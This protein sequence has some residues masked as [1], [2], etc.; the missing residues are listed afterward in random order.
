[1]QRDVD[2]TVAVVGSGP[3]GAA[4]AAYLAEAGV[5]TLL[6]DHRRFP[7]SKACGEYLN[8]LAVAR[9][10]ELGVAARL[11]SQAAILRGMRLH[12]HHESV[13]FPFERELWSLPRT[14]MDDAIRRRA[15]SAGAQPLTARVL[16]VEDEAQSVVLHLRDE[17]GVKRAVRAAYAVGA[18]GMHSTVARRKIPD[19]AGIRFAVGG[20]YRIGTSLEG[21]VEMFRTPVGYLALNPL[22][23]GNANAMCV[24]R[25]EA[26]H[27]WRHDVEGAIRD[28]S[29]EASNG[30]RTLEPHARDGERVSI[31]PLVPFER[32]AT[33][34]HRVLVGDA[35]AFLDPFTGQGIAF[36]LTGASLASAA[37]VRVLRQ[38]DSQAL[39]EYG[40]SIARFVRE[41]R[42]VAQLIEVVLQQRILA[43]IA[44]HRVRESPSL[45]R[46]LVELV[47]GTSRDES[48]LLALTHLA[49]AAL[50]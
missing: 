43:H 21:W 10:A 44:A 3:A 36:A 12:A 5:D 48:P 15:I 35:A 39:L 33:E 42:R 25:A 27:S 6:I 34:K 20:H 23:G 26:L 4:T 8:E 38:N 45:T 47:A 16:S 49:G 50:R 13:E 9:L 40:Q 28:F 17:R 2:V 7:R 24:V 41:R 14:V 11:R 46:A 18:D 37:L 31:G 30:R 29:A 32:V 1:M 19:T 22:A